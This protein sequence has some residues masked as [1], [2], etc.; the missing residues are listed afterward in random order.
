MRPALTAL[1]FVKMY[2]SQTEDQPSQGH[3]LSAVACSRP[4]PGDRA[5]SD[6][7]SRCTR[8]DGEALLKAAEKRE[9]LWLAGERVSMAAEVKVGQRW[10]RMSDGEV[11]VIESVLKRPNDARY[12][13]QRT[14]RAGNIYVANLRRRYLLVLE[15]VDQ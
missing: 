9:S 10:W 2:L 6:A 5:K 1:D 14:G 3:N 15:E 4:R 12:R 11:I 13:N 7:I 8:C